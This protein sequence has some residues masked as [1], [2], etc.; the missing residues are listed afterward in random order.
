MADVEIKEATSWGLVDG[1]TTNPSLIAKAGRPYA[2][3][4]REICNLMDGPV[5]A[6][7]IATEAAAMVEEGEKLAR[8]H[9]NIVVKCPLT[10]K[11]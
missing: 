11:D 7:V 9:P 8:L 4:L 6:E 3:V 10:W 5:S 2:E 1:V